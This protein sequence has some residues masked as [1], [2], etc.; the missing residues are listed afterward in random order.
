MLEAALFFFF[1]ALVFHSHS[2][3]SPPL[4]I[5]H[6]VGH[7]GQRC[8]HF[9]FCAQRGFYLRTTVLA[10]AECPGNILDALLKYYKI[11]LEERL[12]K[13]FKA[14]VNLSRRRIYPKVNYWDINTPCMLAKDGQYEAPFSRVLPHKPFPMSFPLF[15][16]YLL[17]HC[18]LLP[19][20]WLCMYLFCAA[21]IGHPQRNKLLPLKRKWLTLTGRLFVK[22]AGGHF[23][24]HLLDCL[25][26]RAGI[27]SRTAGPSDVR[28]ISCT[29]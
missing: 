13:T 27:R 1:F 10:G 11:L 7:A 5:M 22:T 9:Q 6:G 17:C 25:V 8:V 24:G 3:L 4:G 2:F 21:G 14:G 16:K 18:P 12:L 28:S 20:S 29:T 15:G 19:P 23:L 26:P